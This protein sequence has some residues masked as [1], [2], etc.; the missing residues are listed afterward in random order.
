M[1]RTVIAIGSLL[2]WFALAS[3]FYLIIVNRTASVL[4][5]IFRYF[6]FFTILTNILVAVCLTTLLIKPQSRLGKFFLRP[7]A[8]TAITVY[9]TIV[10][11][12]YNVILRSIWDPTGLQRIVDELLHS[13]IPLLFM[14]YWLLFVPKADLEWRDI[15]TWLIYPLIYIICILSRGALS[16]FYPY[17][18]IDVV[19][20]GYDRV[21][22]NSAGLMVVFVVL[23][24]VFLGRGQIIRNRF[25]L[26]TI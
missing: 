4:E 2:G 9:I 7:A 22:I 15:L 8:L 1:K 5:T 11:I 25:L 10:G 20:I 17:P 16:E 18:F 21:L 19:T 14:F 13:V 26:T 23:S 3:Q 24:L 12:V 6:S